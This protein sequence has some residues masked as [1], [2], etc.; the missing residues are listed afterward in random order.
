MVDAKRLTKTFINLT[1][2]ESL[3]GKEEEIALSVKKELNQ[4]GLESRQDKK[5]NLIVKKSGEG[6][7]LLICCHMDTVGP[8]SR[9]RTVLKDGVFRSDGSTILGADNKAAVAA[10]L[11]FLKILKEKRIKT[12][13]LE[14]IFTVQEELGSKGA[15]ALAFSKIESKKGIILD[16]EGPFGVITSAAPFYYTIDIKIKGKSSHAGLE[17]EKGVN[18]I[19][20]ASLAI[21]HIKQ[22]RINKETTVNIGKIKGGEARNTIPGTVGVQAETRSLNN[23]KAKDETKKIVKAFQKAAKTYG[24]RVSVKIINAAPG[25]KI[26]E[27]DSFVQEIKNILREFGFRTKFLP[28]CS[29]SDANILNAKGVKTLNLT[30]GAQSTHT[31]KENIALE[32][33]KN[34]VKSL[35]KISVKQKKKA[36]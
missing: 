32:D 9:V 30:Y 24:G 35:L 5:G 16:R 14:I 20:I 10:V 12:C 36:H 25:F 33:L 13:P 17:P 4:L 28:T 2:I 7:P 34:M 29:G 26:K 22:G 18:A 31:T 21:S 8:C 27:S 6:I 1:K 15:S 23:K 11:E 19:A 3:S